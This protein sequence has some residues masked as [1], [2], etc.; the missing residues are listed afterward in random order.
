MGPGA[1]GTCQ[2]NSQSFGP[3]VFSGPQSRRIFPHSRVGL[4]CQRQMMR[5][6]LHAQSP[7]PPHTR[8]QRRERTQS[9]VAAANHWRQ[10]ARDLII[11]TWGFAIGQVNPAAMSRFVVQSLC[12]Y[13]EPPIAQK[14]SPSINRRSESLGRGPD[15]QIEERLLPRPQSRL[16]RAQSQT[17]GS[18][19]RAR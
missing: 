5:G 1:R 18:K 6:S 9:A 4:Q 7:W 13:S 10:C 11:A 12:Q 2:F 17:S 16:P 14:K 8:K 15:Q 19:R 3:R